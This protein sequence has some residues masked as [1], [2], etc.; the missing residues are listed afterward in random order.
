M[1][2]TNK[3][4]QVPPSMWERRKPASEAKC[5]RV[6]IRFT[7][8]QM[9][10][11]TDR[12]ARRN[13]GLAGYCRAKCMDETPA[14]KSEETRA[15]MRAASREANNINRITREMHA[16]GLTTDLLTQLEAIAKKIENV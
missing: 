6:T 4:R 5:F 16:R 7:K 9:D 14:D 3:N 12:A 11:I 2:T 13:I 8:G 15:F 10:T 1:A